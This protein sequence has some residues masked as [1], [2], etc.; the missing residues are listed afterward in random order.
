VKVTCLVGEVKHFIEH[1]DLTGA[2][3]TP[4]TLSHVDE[5]LYAF[6]HLALFPGS[7]W[8]QLNTFQNEATL[9]RIDIC[10]SISR[11]FFLN[12]LK[13]IEVL[14]VQKFNK[15]TALNHIWPFE[16]L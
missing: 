15:G 7:D 13:N 2:H 8:A 14:G 16:H 3:D 9:S 1:R 6:N 4:V 11:L 5:S 12:K 10:D